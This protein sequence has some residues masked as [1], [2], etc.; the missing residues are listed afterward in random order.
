MDSLLEYRNCP[1]CGRDDFAT[2][3]DSNME[4][5]DL[6]KDIKT[7]YMLW[8]EAH[9]RHVKCRNCHLIYVNPIEKTSKINADYSKMGNTD[10][11]IIRQPRLTATES[12]V[13]LIKRYGNGTHLLDIGCG[14]GFFLF[15]AS[16][17]GYTTKGVELSQ[18]AATYARE[19]FGLDVEGKPFEKM[20]LPEDYF[21]VVTMWQVLEHL[22]YPMATL[23]EIHRILK[24]GGLLAT[25]TP[26][27]EGIMARILRRKW[28]NLR[29][30]HINQFTAK[31][32]ADI[33]T[34]AGFKNVFSTSY[35]EYVSLSMLVIPLL[36][37]LKVY[38]QTRGVFHP[39]SSS[40]KI[41][42]K[43]TLAYSSTLDNCTV[44]GF[45]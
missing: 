25:S 11:P 15:N 6:Q 4:E 23:K 3:F 35:R 36:K 40:G 43:L 32:L 30:L 8:G 22:P 29:R 24:P 20:H 42:N 45:K 21:D 39:D 44:I 17:A 27:I 19:E 34:R 13:R 16:K 26:D 9:G 1:S 38:E 7:V 2:I 28:W 14:E 5:D 41:M 12:Q 33:L 10:A 37:R 18:H 31:T